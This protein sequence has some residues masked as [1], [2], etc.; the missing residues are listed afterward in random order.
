MSWR[1][2]VAA[3]LVAAC[4]APPRPTPPA[5]APPVDAGVDAPPADP[6][7][8]TLIA[9]LT[10]QRDRACA[11]PDAA[12]ADEAA[13]LAVQW[14]L[15]HPDVPRSARPSPAQEAEITALLDAAEA[16][17]DARLGHGPGA[18]HP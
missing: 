3:A 13:A 12:C 18:P 1:G 14:G 7:A 6:A 8:A 11:C 10:E 15:D 5:P 9:A 2:V 16:C 17:L 4:G